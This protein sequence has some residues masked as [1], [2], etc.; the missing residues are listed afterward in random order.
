MT[1]DGGL[2]S[3]E[4]KG[5]LQLLIN[6]GALGKARGRKRGRACACARVRAR[7]QRDWRIDEFAGGAGWAERIE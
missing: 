3:M 5:D 1:R 7:A 2:Q 6:D 4:V